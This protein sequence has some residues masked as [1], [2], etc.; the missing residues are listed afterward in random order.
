M[1]ERVLMTRTLMVG[2]YPLK[3]EIVEVTSPQVKKLFSDIKGGT[4]GTKSR[5]VGVEPLSGA[6]IKIN[7]FSVALAATFGLTAG[8]KTTV[9]IMSSYQNDNGVQSVEQ[10]IWYGEIMDM[11]DEGSKSTGSDS[12]LQSMSINFANLDSA[13]KYLDGKTIHN[14]NLVTDEIDFGSGDILQAH[15]VAVGRP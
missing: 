11:T 9:T 15:R 14:I 4:F 1:A 13:E 8:E 6:S 7:D 12:A 10:E 3:R 2:V 5:C